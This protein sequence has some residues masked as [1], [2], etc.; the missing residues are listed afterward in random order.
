MSMSWQAAG[1]AGWKR[2]WWDVN[3]P[4]K[5][6]QSQLDITGALAHNMP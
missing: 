5:A 2:G 3:S 1:D 4:R 6:V